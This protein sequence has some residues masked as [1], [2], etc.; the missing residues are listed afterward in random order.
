[1]N[2]AINICKAPI[3]KIVDCP[4]Q[5]ERAP[6]PVER[7]IFAEV[8]DETPVVVL[9]LKSWGELVVVIGTRYPP[10]DAMV[11]DVFIQGGSVPIGWFGVVVVDVICEV[12]QE[13]LAVEASGPLVNSIIPDPERL[14]T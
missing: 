8:V 6:E 1:M 11:L 14:P 7:L 12:I 13:E 4:E 9:V 10:V 3:N 5:Y 2:N